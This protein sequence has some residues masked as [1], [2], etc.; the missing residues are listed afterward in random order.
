MFGTT[1]GEGAYARVSDEFKSIAFE[2]LKIEI[3]GSC[4]F[5]KD[6]GGICG[7]NYGETIH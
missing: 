5:K 2:F 6:W 7:E 1:L 3:G 4:A